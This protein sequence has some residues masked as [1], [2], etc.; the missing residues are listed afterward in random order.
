MCGATRGRG[1]RKERLVAMD[2]VV[3]EVV[4]A[5]GV[6]VKARATP[7]QQPATCRPRRPPGQRLTVG[8]AIQIRLNPTGQVDPPGI[9]LFVVGTYLCACI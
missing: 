1:G 2:A 9:E 7:L 4:D 3:V 5:D 8:S 6:V